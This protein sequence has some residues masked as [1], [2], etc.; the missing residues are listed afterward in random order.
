MTL[1]TAVQIPWGLVGSLLGQGAA[2][3]AEVTALAYVVAVIISFVAGLAKMA[4]WL[5]IRFLATLYVEVFRGTSAIV[6][7]YFFFFVLPLVGFTLPALAAG[8]AAL[9]LN[10]GA[11]GAEI[12]RAG[13][14]GVDPGQREA[15]VSLNMSPVLTMRRVILPQAVVAM[16]PPFGNMIVE[17]LKATSLVSLITLGELTFRAQE[18]N[19][20]TADPI[21][22]YSL[23]LLL[24]FIM[25]Y[26]LTRVVRLVERRVT[27]GL[28][29]VRA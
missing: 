9:G 16:L 6:Q 5:P 28:Q 27:R 23:V 25:A 14:Q 3:T 4:P 10:F 17:V 7:V 11:Y 1:G 13:I 24:Y 20:V 2:I 15:A 19:E 22:I 29:M 21:V 18:L 8:V 12:V 26:P